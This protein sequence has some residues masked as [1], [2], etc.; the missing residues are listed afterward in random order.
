MRV[1]DGVV[2][3]ACPSGFAV[4]D[5]TRIRAL[6][7]KNGDLCVPCQGVTGADGISCLSSS[8]ACNEL[9]LATAADGACACIEGATLESN[10]CVCKAET[11]FLSLDGSHCGPSCPADQ[12]AAEVVIE[13][14]GVQI[15]AM[16]C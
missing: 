6:G 5:G 8:E 10:A 14:G 13:V 1:I 9:G 16:Q 2:T 12:A 11:P 3:C 4:E 15:S 7:A